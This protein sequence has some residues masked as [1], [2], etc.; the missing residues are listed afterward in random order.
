MNKHYK[1]YLYSYF[2]QNWQYSNL[3]PVTY[4]PVYFY[5][6]VKN[7]HIHLIWICKQII[8]IMLHKSA[9]TDLILDQVYWL[10]QL[11]ITCYPEQ[12]I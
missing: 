11:T 2:Q 3:Q 12:S 5:A 4:L 8:L 6:M 9:Y 1:K 7:L 10:F